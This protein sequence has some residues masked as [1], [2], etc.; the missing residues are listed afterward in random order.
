MMKVADIYVRITAYLFQGIDIH[1]WRI[2]SQ[3]CMLA[4]NLSHKISIDTYAKYRLKNFMVAYGV[5]I[6]CALNW[7]KAE[8]IGK[9]SMLGFQKNNTTLW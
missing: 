6:T 7:V 5:Y 8:E 1:W 4:H 3:H 2:D 9:H